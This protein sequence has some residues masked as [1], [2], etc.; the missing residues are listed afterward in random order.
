MKLVLN[1]KKIE[2]E[3]RPTILQIARDNGVKIPS[4]CDHED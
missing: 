3:G 2:V 4:L 1:G